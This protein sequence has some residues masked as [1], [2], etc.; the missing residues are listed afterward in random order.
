MQNLSSTLALAGDAHAADPVAHPAWTRLKNAVEALRPL[1]SK[2]GSIDL[3]A[4]P[5]PTVDPLVETVR[6]AVAELAPLFPHDAAYLDAVRTDLAKWADTGYREPDFL[7]SLLAFRPNEHRVDGTGH[8][9]VFPM[10]TQNG[11]PDRNLEAVLLKVVWPDWIA[12][13]ERTRFDNPGYLGIAFED[14]TAGYDTNS[15]VLFPRPWPS[16]KRR[17]VSPG[18]ASSVTAKPPASAPSPPAP[19]ASSTST[20]PPTPPSCSGTRTAPSRPS[21]CGTWSTTA[22]TATAT[23]RS[24]PS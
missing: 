3:S 5:R 7:D 1:Q 10:Y 6:A 8:L 19:S 9:V 21:S 22:P 20:S 4:V 15:A 17:N 2:D 12:E 18:A 11:N 24:T 16:A 13:L 23:C 14:F